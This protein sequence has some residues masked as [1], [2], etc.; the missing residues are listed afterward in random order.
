MEDSIIIS[1]LNF[2]FDGNNFFNNFNLNIKKGN[3][4]TVIGPNGCGKTTLIKILLGFYPLDTYVNI[5]KNAVCKDNYRNIR[6]KVGAV[7]ERPD[8]SFV[9]ETVLDEIAFSVENMGLSKREIR[10][11]INEIVNALDI[12]DILECYPQ[13]LS[14]GQKQLVAIASALVIKPKVLLLDE[15]MTMIDEKYKDKVVKLLKKL[16][17]EENL[18]ILSVTHDIEDTL[19][20]N[21]VVVMDKGNIV[22]QGATKDVLNKDKLLIKLGLDIPF[23]VKLSTKLKYYGLLK[24]IE[25]LPTKMVDEIWK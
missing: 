23:M 8:D 25:L 4:T 15:A 7:F 10:N 5:N 6:S 12:K 13:S 3:W 11:R 9:A 17:K 16:N 19:Y 20:G 1:K 14:G 24:D 18:T 2:G 21:E 22:L